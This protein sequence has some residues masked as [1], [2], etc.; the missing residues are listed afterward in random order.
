MQQGGCLATSQPEHLQGFVPSSLAS[1]RLLQGT[2][3]RGD[4]LVGTLV[5]LVWQGFQSIA[6]ETNL[7]AYGS[8][9]CQVGYHSLYSSSSNFLQ[10]K[11]QD[12]C[13]ILSK[14]SKW[15]FKLNGRYNKHLGMLVLFGSFFMFSNLNRYIHISKFV[16]HQQTYNETY[17]KTGLKIRPPLIQL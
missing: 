11:F 12:Y 1:R 3:N 15:A 9:F 6:L 2:L 8:S 17:A 4:W 14:C 7:V 16:V 13:T 10:L 5:P